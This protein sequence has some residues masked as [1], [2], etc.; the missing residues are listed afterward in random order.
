MNPVIAL[1]V[2]LF[3]LIASPITLA[4]SA[5]RGSV[6]GLL[7]AGLGLAGACYGMAATVYPLLAR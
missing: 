2:S 7:T 5:M 4:I 6:V 3:L 1:A